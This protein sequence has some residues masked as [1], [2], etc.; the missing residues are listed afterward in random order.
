LSKGVSAVSIEFDYDLAVACSNFWDGGIGGGKGGRHGRV[1]RY[2]VLDNMLI[3]LIVS[4]P[5]E[6]LG[7]DIRAG[8]AETDHSE[9]SENPPP[10]IRLG[11]GGCLALFIYSSSAPAHR[12]LDDA[13][14]HL[15]FSP[16][17]F[18]SCDSGH[19]QIIVQFLPW[20]MRCAAE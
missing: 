13:N 10:M 8:G 2:P 19:R 4:A 1:E 12:S 7:G 15:S 20:E 17:D 14:E 18:I 3:L 9:F 16:V 6:W 11:S 5:G